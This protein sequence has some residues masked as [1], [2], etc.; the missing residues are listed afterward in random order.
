LKEGSKKSYIFAFT[1]RD[2]N[3]QNDTINGYFLLPSF[4]SCLIKPVR[5]PKGRVVELVA[6]DNTPINGPSFEGRQQKI[7]YFCLH[8]TGYQ[9]AK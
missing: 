2:I 5:D 6:S 8:P 1:P 3:W 9:L 4:K 7:L